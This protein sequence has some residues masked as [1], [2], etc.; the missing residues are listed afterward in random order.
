MYCHKGEVK[1]K[2]YEVYVVKSKN[3]EVLYVGE[4]LSGRHKHV[5]SG[6]SHVYDLNK[7]YF[8]GRKLIVRVV[9]QGNTKQ[10]AISHEKLLIDT[11]KPKFNKQ[12]ITQAGSIDYVSTRKKLVDSVL[13]TC[14]KELVSKDYFLLGDMLKYFGVGKMVEG[15]TRSDLVKTQ[16]KRKTCLI[17][18][19]SELL[20]E[21][22]SNYFYYVSKTKI[23]IH[24]KFI[25]YKKAKQE[26]FV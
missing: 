20:E 18:P 3:G 26:D 14:P 1:T 25:V 24:K 22:Y 11:L 21:R 23:A 13:E 12:S 2:S 8:S 16:I 10:G 9:W 6:V 19:S 15:F 5:S 7:F 17:G 4:G